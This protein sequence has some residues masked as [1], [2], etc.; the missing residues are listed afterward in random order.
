MEK[1]SKRLSK[2]HAKE[3]ESAR[4]REK[5]YAADQAG[6]QARLNKELAQMIKDAGVIDR[7]NPM[8]QLRAYRRAECRFQHQRDVKLLERHTKQ[9][10]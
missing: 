2:T 5:K 1:H 9:G 6:Y 10:E 4:K 7:L 8:D 3:I